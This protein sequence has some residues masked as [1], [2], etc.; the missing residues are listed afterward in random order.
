MSEARPH[1]YR[2]AAALGVLAQLL[3][4][5][6][7]TI[8]TK[9]MFDETHYVPA[10]RTL[11]ALSGPTNIEHPL[12]AKEIIAGGILLFGDNS[13][14]W[15]F[16]STL[17]GTAT[18]L[19]VFAIV[20]LMVGRVRPAVF[21]ALFTLFNFTVFVQ[22]RI[23]MLDGFM[24]AFVVTGLAALL[25]AM[26]APDGR[27]AWA[28]WIGGAVLLGLAVAAKWIAAP[29]IAFAALGF[30]LLRL[31][32][33]RLRGRSVFA[34]LNAGT[35]RHWPGM[36]AIPAVLVL[37]AV[38]IAT[39][40]A[41]FA[42]AFF[43]LHDPMT[44]GTLLP[45][46][47]HMYDRQTMPLPKH[48]YQSGWWSWP[49]MVRPIWYLY[50]R[51]DGAQRGVLLIGNVAILWG[52]LIAVA[53]CL[54]EGVRARSPRL[55]AAAGLWLGSYAIWVVIPKK[56]GF[57]Y[58]YYLPSIAL[59]VALSLAFDHFPAA[60]RRDTAFLAGVIALFAIFYPVL[61]AAALPGPGAFRYWTWSS[62]WV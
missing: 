5:Y 57:F 6:R 35:N 14:G 55:L 48:P 10:A 39:Y 46:Q 20:L 51:V 50:E 62:T 45:F 36:A 13:L 59:C 15:R 26:R 7:L 23:G 30:I 60:R 38:S 47:K 19:G 53:A 43:Y 8:P 44:L 40:L 16:F 4:S 24:A 49:I 37:G 52:G 9:L 17:A 22:A 27:H 41:T 12:L 29:L 1:P 56:I 33:A 11:I 61:S 18:V 25:W 34:A 42:P 3:F 21:G 2:A 28:R 54:V 31:H 58:Y 32:D